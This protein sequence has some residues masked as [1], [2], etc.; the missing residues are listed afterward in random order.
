MSRTENDIF[1]AYKQEHGED[2]VRWREW[3]RKYWM[4]QIGDYFERKWW[5]VPV[6]KYSKRPLAGFEW[7]KRRLGFEEAVWD[8]AQGLNI[9]VVAR[10]LV[11]LDMD[12]DSK[13]P[14]DTGTLTMKTPK[15]YQY[16]CQG[17]Y[18]VALQEKVRHLGFDVPRSGVMFSLVPLSRTCRNDKGGRC[19]C[20][21]HDFRFREW[22]NFRAECLPFRKVVRDFA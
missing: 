15:G 13:K 12:S 16:W 8:A 19:S 1:D 11:I 21:T 6:G 17:P 18:D 5:L 2:G 10:D 4:D 3:W 7:S 22:V 9:A 14:F 20:F